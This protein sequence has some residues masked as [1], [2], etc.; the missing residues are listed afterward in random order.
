MVR[1]TVGSLARLF[2]DPGSS[3]HMFHMV[4]GQDTK[5]SAVVTFDLAVSPTGEMCSNI[6]KKGNDGQSSISCVMVSRLFPC[7]PQYQS[8]RSHVW[9]Q[10]NQLFWR[11]KQNRGEQVCSVCVQSEIPTDLT[12]DVFF[13]YFCS[14]RPLTWADFLRESAIYILASRP[15]SSATHIR[16]PL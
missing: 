12:K 14:I 16:L 8:R 3:A 15:N 7:P 11:A 2:P 5:I 13:F 4:I 9:E 6:L 10:P 1:A